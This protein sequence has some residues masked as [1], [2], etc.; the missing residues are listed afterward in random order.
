MLISV[1]LF[2]FVDDV[3]EVICYEDLRV[4]W[5]KACR[6]G[7]VYRLSV[8]ERALYRVCMIYCRFGGRI[9]SLVVL[10]KLKCIIEKLKFTLKREALKIGFGKICK[11]ISNVVILNLFPKIIDW[12]INKNYILYIGFMEL[13]NPPHIKTY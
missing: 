11:L 5:V 4:L 13:N 9:K 3:I 1:W 12:I 7:N 8:F 6:N 10:E 2:M